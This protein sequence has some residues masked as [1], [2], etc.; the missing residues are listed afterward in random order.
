MIGDPNHLAFEN[1][2]PDQDPAEVQGLGWGNL[3]VWLAGRAVWKS[4]PYAQPVTWT[5][6]DLVEHLARAWGF[7]LHEEIYPFGLVAVGPEALRTRALLTSVPLTSSPCR[8]RLHEVGQAG[9]VRGQRPAI[10]GT[11]RSGSPRRVIRCAIAG[12]PRHR[13][14]R[15]AATSDPLRGS[16][17]GRFVPSPQKPGS[18]LISL[19]VRISSRVEILRWS[20]KPS[21]QALP[22]PRRSLSSRASTISSSAA[23]PSTGPWTGCSRTTTTSCP[24]IASS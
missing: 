15:L 7:L 12:P 16:W 19:P 14:R 1:T 21:C 22:T 9:T 11:R 23:A 5:W 18:A 24:S 10:A 13:R 2:W 4:D 20:Y 8:G 17:S 3:T 6:I